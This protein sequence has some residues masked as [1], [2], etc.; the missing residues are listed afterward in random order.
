M[1]VV[2]M[3][4]N[5]KKAKGIITDM[6]DDCE[7]NYSL[8]SEDSCISLGFHSEAFE[9]WRIILVI[10]EDDLDY[11]IYSNNEVKD[12]LLDKVLLFMNFVNNEEEYKVYMNEYKHVLCANHRGLGESDEKLEESA[13]FILG[14][15]FSFIKTYDTGFA[16]INDGADPL[17]AFIACQYKANVKAENSCED[18]TEGETD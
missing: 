8:N 2:R 13:R 18:D 11:R 7:M 10:S 15:I 4:W 3:A 14:S 5:N 12:E 6:L 9:G 16:A 17:D 1:G